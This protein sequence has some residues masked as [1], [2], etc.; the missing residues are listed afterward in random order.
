MFESAPHLCELQRPYRPVSSSKGR[1]L[2][3]GAAQFDS[4][5]IQG[6]KVASLALLLAYGALCGCGGSS[7]VTPSNLVGSYG[8]T[9][10]DTAGGASNGTSSVTITTP[11]TV[12]FSLQYTSG[13]PTQSGGGTVDS[14]G[15][16]I[17]EIN[18]QL[19]NNPATGMI[20][21]T[22]NGISMTITYQLTPGAPAAS[23]TWYITAAKLLP[24]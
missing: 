19:H 6:V 2:L 24:Q 22:A 7:V 17:G 9:W 14:Q 1:D 18:G 12:Q 11:N 3:I 23:Q 8:G 21:Q 20:T 10:T 13:A 15:N 4:G 16:F 5:R